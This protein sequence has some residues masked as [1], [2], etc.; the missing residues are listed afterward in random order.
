MSA[1]SNFSFTTKLNGDL[2]TV[3]GDSFEEFHNHLATAVSEAQSLLTDIGLLQAAGH[4]TPV[5]VA[6][7]PIPAAAPAAAAVSW[8][9]PAAAPAPSFAA[10]AVPS[11]DHGPRVARGGVSGKGPWKAWFCNTPKDTPGQ[12]KP[13]FLVSPGNKG[14]NASEWNAF[15]A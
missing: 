15:P 10:A 2:F 1:E 8:D 11:C 6:S 3:R 13:Q 7:A 4:A 14:H 12:C 5:V 9:T